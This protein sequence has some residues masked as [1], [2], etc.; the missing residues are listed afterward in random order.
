[1]EI[2]KRAKGMSDGEMTS[3]GHKPPSGL[4]D[5]LNHRTHKAGYTDSDGQKIVSRSSGAGKGDVP[6][7]VNKK[8][9][10]R[11]YERIFGHK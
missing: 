7:P 4:Q 2:L 6:R 9:Y 8:L 1:M 11:N 3:W 10:D 5:E